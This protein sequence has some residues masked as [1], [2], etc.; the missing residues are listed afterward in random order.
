LSAVDAETEANIVRALR[1]GDLFGGTR[2][3]LVVVSHR[4]SATLSADEIVVFDTSAQ[5]GQVVER[6]TH[7][8]LLAA[9][10]LYGDLWGTEQLKK[11]WVAT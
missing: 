9:G 2:P 6:G 1:S 10:G 8:Q 4:L 7:A 5:G 3:T 11:R